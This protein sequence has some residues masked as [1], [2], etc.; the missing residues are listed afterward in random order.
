MVMLTHILL[1]RLPRYPEFIIGT[2]LENLSNFNA[3]LSFHLLSPRHSVTPLSG[4]S[5]VNLKNFG[6]VVKSLIM[7]VVLQT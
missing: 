4:F 2:W 7:Y 6:G 3:K 1:M 5:G